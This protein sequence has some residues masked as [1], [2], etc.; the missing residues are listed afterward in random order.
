MTNTLFNKVFA[1]CNM[2]LY[3]NNPE[4][5]KRLYALGRVSDT[6]RGITTITL[7]QFKKFANENDIFWYYNRPK[8]ESTPFTETE[9]FKEGV[10]EGIYTKE[11]VDELRKTWLE[12]YWEKYNADFEKG[13]KGGQLVKRLVEMQDDINLHNQKKRGKMKVNVEIAKICHEA[14]QEY[15]I[16]NQLKPQANW[17]E[18]SEEIQSSIIFGVTK[19]LADPKITAED[20]HKSWLEYK[21][22]EGWEYGKKFDLEKRL[23]P[24]MVPFKKLPPREQGKD[25]LF[26]RTVKEEMEK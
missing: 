9:V 4:F 5:V 12:G 26:I 21:T 1:G 24:N 15:C 8:W 10:R 2:E 20:I 17:N 23:H 19:V 22:V 11:Q 14:N 6:M 16:D 25:R 7:E 13:Y 3:I 18:L